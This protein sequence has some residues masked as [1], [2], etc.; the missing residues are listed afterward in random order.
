MSNIIRPFIIDNKNFRGKLVRIDE[1]L[2]SILSS[3]SYHDAI[4]KILGESLVVLSMIGSDLKNGGII[5]LQ[6][7]SEGDIKIFVADITGEL[8]LRGY[9]EY[10]ENTNFSER[11]TAKSLF[12]N[13]YL[14]VT[15]DPAESH[16]RY[17][18]IVDI[19][20]ENISDM[21]TNYITNSEQIPTYIKTLVKKENGKWR[22]AGLIIQKMPD[23]ES[24]EV[25]NWE[26]LEIFASS[27][28][29]YELISDNIS[30][31]DLLTRLFGTH[32]V[33]AFEQRQIIA[34]CRCSHL[35]ALKLLQS[36][37]KEELESLKVDGKLIVKCNYCNKTNEFE[38]I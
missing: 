38:H 1:A 12:G 4:S 11:S 30:D 26:E 5:T 32:E 31:T 35:R 27:V 8:H 22:G 6:F 21:L 33:I 15:I 34:K 19:K 14:V 29:D 36:L 9:V 24:S 16:Q 3:H 37:D 25:E 20:G 2:D 13:G 7:Q 10:N 28:R 17:Q 23:S 18:G